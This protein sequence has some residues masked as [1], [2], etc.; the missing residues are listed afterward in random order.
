MAS[1][2]PARCRLVRAGGCVVSF[3][4]SSGEPTTFDVPSFYRTHG[5]RLAAFLIF[6]ELQ[7]TGSAVHDLVNL[8]DQLATGRL[9]VD[10]G[11]ELPWRE[12]ARA[13][14]ALDERRFAGKA[15]LHVDQ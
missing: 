13:F 12:A 9:V 15:V 10:V 7:R 1:R 4:C 5:A 14:E 11:L 8:A 2:S 6:A 3:G